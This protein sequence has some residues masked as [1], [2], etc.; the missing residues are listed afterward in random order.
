[1]LQNCDDVTL[2]FVHGATRKVS[3]GVNWSSTWWACESLSRELLTPSRKLNV[4]ASMWR[5]AKLAVMTSFNL[6]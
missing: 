5:H 3:E 2:E 1:M 6:D 4:D